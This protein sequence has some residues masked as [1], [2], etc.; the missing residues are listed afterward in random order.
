MSR[1]TESGNWAICKSLQVND[2]N[3]ENKE[4]KIFAFLI[5]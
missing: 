4:C 2:L 3:K 5:M 1:T